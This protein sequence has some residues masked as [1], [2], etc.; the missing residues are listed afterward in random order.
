MTWRLGSMV[1][2][3]AM[4]A[5]AT[6]ERI[7]VVAAPGTSPEVAEQL[8]ETLCVSME[9]VP[10]QD[11]LSRGKTDYKKVARGGVAAVVGA[12]RVKA[13]KSWNVELTV[14][15][16]GGELRFKHV[17]PA[18][19]SGRLKVADLMTASAKVLAAIEKPPKKADGDRDQR[20][21]SKA[22]KKKN[23]PKHARRMAHRGAIAQAD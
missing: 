19:G 11:V 10:R 2:L 15:S 3:L 14:H 1:V 17:A 4:P 16:S 13:K 9:C 7:A 22:K 8:R 6:G 12:R 18:S 23:G 5:F 21:A 20:V